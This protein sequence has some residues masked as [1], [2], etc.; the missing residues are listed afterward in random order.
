[1]KS[2]TRSI[3]IRRK[4]SV[5]LLITFMLFT[6]TTIIGQTLQHR[7]QIQ[8]KTSKNSLDSLVNIFAVKSKYEEAAIINY[9]QRNPETK[10]L[11]VKNG[12]VYYLKRISKDGL[13][14]YINTKNRASGEMIGVPQLYN[15]GS[16]GANVTGTG[17]VAG[18][19]D[20][21][22]VRTTHEL[23]TGNVAMQPNQT[24]STQT[25]NDHMTHVSGTM[26]GK[27]ITNQPSARGIAYNGTS[28]NY[29]TN[30]DEAEMAAFGASGYLISNH[31]YGYSND[32]TIP[33]WQFG[34]YDVD[35]RSWDVITKNAP[36]Y[37][38]FVAAGNEQ[39]ANGNSSKNG[40]DII[41]G[42]SASKNVV[43]V[44]ALN[45]DSSMSDYSNWGP[46]DD[47]R[48]KPEIVA[49][50]TGI[51]SSL[52]TGD[53][54]YSGSGDNS[55]GTSYAAPAVAATGLLL[56]QYYHNLTNTYMRSSTLKAI[57][58]HTAF[59]LGNPGPD[60]KFGWG[61]TSADKAGF[62]IKK[63]KATSIP[64]GASITEYNINPV[65]NGTDEI[66]TT[67]IASGTEPL[68]VSIAWV[69]DEGT[70]QQ[71][72]DGIDPTA[73]RLVYHFDILV[74]ANNTLI[75]TR[76]WRPMGM[77]NR[78]AN[79]TKG[80]TWFEGDN[81]NYRQVIIDN[82][83]AGAT[84][85]IAIRKS[86]SSPATVRPFSLIVSGLRISSITDF[87]RTKQSGNWNNTNTWESSADAT[88]WGAATLTPD[89]NSNTITVLNSHTVTITANAT[90]DQT[91]INSGGAVVVN[92]NIVLTVND[93][94]GND[95]TISSGA[96]MTIKSTIAGTGSIGTSAGTLSGNVT[97][98]RYISNKRAWRL[99]SITGTATTQTIKTAWME[100]ATNASSNPVPGY[101]THITT[102]TGDPNAANF[103]AQKPA[104]SIRIYRTDGNFNSDATHTPNVAAPFGSYYTAIFLFVR[105]DRSVDRT[106]TT[107]SSSTILRF[108]GTPNQGN[109]MNEGEKSNS[110]SVINNPYPSSLNFDAIK[111]I[112]TN[113]S[114]N[115]FY[116]WD[117]TLGTV[118]QYRTV[119]ITGTAPNFTYT[120]TPGTTDNNWRFIE[121]GTAFF[122]PGSRTMDFTEATKSSGTPPSSM[123]RTFTGTETELAVNLNKINTDNTIFIA[124]GV[125]LVFDN[126][127]SSAVDKN[128]AKKMSGFETN[129][130]IV[131][132]NEVLAIEKRPLPV[133]SDVISLKLWN[134]APGNYQF[135]MQPANFSSTSL[136]AYLKD[137]F[138]ETYTP[139]NLTGDTKVNF[140][141]TADAASAAA[142]RF[143]IVFAKTVLPPAKA[144]IV[145]YPNPVTNG[146]ITLRINNMPK[147]I[148]GAKLLNTLGQTIMSKQI[149]HGGGSSIQTIGV[150]KIKGT[151]MLEIIN[152]NN[153]KQTNKVVI[154]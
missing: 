13:P 87:F 112:T 16:V 31:S 118:G 120:A 108:T 154:N 8:E 92:P 68:K 94:T 71:S 144:A 4:V 47:G 24:M 90:I 126:I 53:Q 27:D 110:F 74:T 147:G 143:S 141:I 135:E 17:M 62:L 46:T 72:T 79:A 140:A 89:F 64:M 145:I 34:A 130:G 2:I 125:R 42:S 105:G 15:G 124:D 50:G 139:I 59:D 111:A 70:E 44:G 38:P 65:N 103:D 7:I 113:S 20:L 43:T 100:G 78:T 73:G 45:G 152:P 150:N 97:I 49:K 81:N 40:Y 5:S 26:V 123:L 95:L 60:Y 148:Y 22:Q 67:V 132:N 35:A 66:V 1:M 101:G 12:S 63:A 19:W 121:S 96:S 122:I 55:S 109:V 84:Y 33:V 85:T 91:T 104:S 151:Y 116:V 86:S 61:L 76:P 129:F 32:N 134:S 9:L 11:F 77:V 69:D 56:Q 153:S 3:F 106:S 142:N 25:G 107:A 80:T 48:F 99:L 14:V 82:P 115:T 146:L 28:L 41:T 137:N 30:G 117:A 6:G 23:L 57:M 128:D 51:N 131:S 149:N 75:E 133:S 10:R 58:L 93:G 136:F 138:L 37:L 114:I 83:I 39:Q 54:A 29:D 18:I 88:T 127:Y 21:G 36:M 102:F 52:S 119:S 98:E